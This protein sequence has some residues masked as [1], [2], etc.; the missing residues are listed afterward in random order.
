MLPWR[1]METYFLHYNRRIMETY[2]LHYNRRIMETYFLHYNRRIMET[3]FLHYNRRIMETYFLHYNR[4]I[5]ETYFLHYNR[6]IMETYF[7]HYNRISHWVKAAD[8]CKLKLQYCTIAG[9]HKFQHFLAKNDNGFARDCGNF[10][11]PQ[12]IL[13]HCRL[14]LYSMVNFFQI[15]AIM[16]G[17]KFHLKP[18]TKF[19]LNITI[20]ILKQS[21]LSLNSVWQ[22]KTFTHDYAKQ[23]KSL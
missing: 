14:I 20:G 6:R 8:P 16:Q 9:L 23:F 21:L 19:D 11:S 22:L 10:K 1:I 2:F 5:M 15:T 3:Y 17:W 13:I 18:M 12:C 7:L 4:R